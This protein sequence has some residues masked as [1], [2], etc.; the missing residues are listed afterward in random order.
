MPRRPSV[1][2]VS[3][4][5]RQDSLRKLEREAKHNDRSMNDEIM[6]RL[7]DSLAFDDW[8][9]KR[10][11]ILREMR[12]ALERHLDSGRQS[13]AVAADGGREKPPA[14]AK[15]VEK[16]RGGLSVQVRFRL[17]QDIVDKVER[18]AKEHRRSTHDEI[19]VRLEASFGSPDPWE[20]LRPL[21]SALIADAA[22]HDNP[23]ATK[24]AFTKIDA[25]AE[26]DVQEQIMTMLF[27][28]RRIHLRAPRA[29]A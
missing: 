6:R 3:F 13:D 25:E 24:A 7:E 10:E 15:P 5:L 29:A 27:P 20:Q 19:G 11:D 12:T 23:A 4:R 26:R 1:V 17:R 21:I 2:Q 9:E 8:R 16:P 22:S 18:K 14:Q 28:P